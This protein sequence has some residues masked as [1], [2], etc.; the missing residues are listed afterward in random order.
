MYA[1]PAYLAIKRDVIL[2]NIISTII[3]TII[4]SYGMSPECRQHTRTPSTNAI[5]F[6]VP[7][8]NYSI[9]VL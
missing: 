3:I 7:K 9:S 6:F 2:Y 8:Q 5:R 1:V 4:L